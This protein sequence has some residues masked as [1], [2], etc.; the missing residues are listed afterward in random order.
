MARILS[1]DDVGQSPDYGG[2]RA[3]ARR[4]RRRRPAVTRAGPRPDAD[5]ARRPLA[6][7][8]RMRFNGVR[9]Y[10]ERR[11]KGRSCPTDS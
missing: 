11:T 8:R 10:P 5:V 6:T 9:P 1:V 7:R 4:F 3:A 2:G